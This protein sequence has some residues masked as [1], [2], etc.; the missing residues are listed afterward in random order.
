MK[1][2]LL[3]DNEKD[4]QI[5]RLKEIISSFIKYDKERKQ[6]YSKVIQRLGELESFI[7]EIEDGKDD[8]R[9]LENK[10]WKQ[11]EALNILKHKIEILKNDRDIPVHYE[12]LSDIMAINE[13]LR[14]QNEDLNKSLNA[15]RELSFEYYK[16]M[17]DNNLLNN[18]TEWKE[19][20]N[21]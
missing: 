5:I 11:R 3:F 12:H 10:I 18:F 2:K 21:L 4:Y 17:K 19:N 15:V 20:L 8:V 13:Y 14:K 9:I 1:R 16:Y 7:E 6:Y